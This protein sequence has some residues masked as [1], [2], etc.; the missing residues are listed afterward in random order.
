MA[1]ERV[2]KRYVHALRFQWLTPAYDTIIKTT[3]REQRF[4]QALISQAQLGAGHQVLDV[5]CGTGTLAI[6]I[7]QRHPDV[8]VTGIDGEPAI[9]AIARQKAQKAGVSV[10]F[11]QALAY[12]LPFPDHCFDRVF[13]SLLLH[14]MVWEDK[15]RTAREVFRV[16]KPGGT[17]HVADWGAPAHRIMRLLFFS[18]QLLDGFEQ[19]RD[20]VTGRLPELFA[21]AG[22]QEVQV[23]PSFSTL[24]G[25]LTLYQG[26]R[27][28]A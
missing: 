10:V 24:Y 15:V 6:W 25:T 26:R 22:F 5:G 4:K 17:W 3:T 23:G 13:S 7:K 18:I 27:P 12:S 19:T 9:L 1:S 8:S 20:H 2:R 14:H 16:L 11:K 21:R 28:L